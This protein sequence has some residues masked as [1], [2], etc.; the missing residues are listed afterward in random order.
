MKTVKTTETIT[1]NRDEIWNTYDL[2]FRV[3]STMALLTE[4]VT[5]EPYQDAISCLS[6]Y[7]RRILRDLNHLLDS[8]ETPKA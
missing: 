3:N 1:L 7:M 5:A 6:D 4:Q 2:L 8:A